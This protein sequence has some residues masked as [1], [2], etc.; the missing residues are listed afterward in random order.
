MAKRKRLDVPT[1]PIPGS[2]ETKTAVSGPRARMPIAEVASDTAGRAALEEVAREMT[3]AETEG[4]VIKK[5]PLKK[6]IGFH[7]CRDRM[8]VDP[9]DMAALQASIADRGQQTP[10]EVVRIGDGKFGLISGLRRM[11]ALRALGH[12]HA[13]A[14]IRQPDSAADSYRAMIEENEIRADLSFY[15]RANIAFAVVGQ[16]IYPDVRAAVAGLYAH[17]T[18]AKRSKI[19]K[20]TVLR[21]TLGASLRFPTA[22]PEHLGF[23]LAQAIEAERAFASRVSA[24]L[25]AADPEDAAAERKVLEQMLKR[26]AKAAPA[27]EEVAPGLTLEVRKGRVVLA[28]QGVDAPLLEALRGF[29]VSHAKNTN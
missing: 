18:P 15:E 27:R 14:L 4:R 6:I 3:A 19:V 24:A 28:G 12:T 17:A 22:I 1:E 20:F 29:L 7:L 11:E 8:V 13:L 16:R 26:P 25:R 23:A 10:I 21:E 9:D 5:V 2:L